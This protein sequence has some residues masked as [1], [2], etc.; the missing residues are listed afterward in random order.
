VWVTSSLT[1]I[2]TPTA[3]ALGNFDGIHRGHQVVL[4]PILEFAAQSADRPIPTVVTFHPHPRAFFSGKERPLLTPLAEKVE[5][6]SR[7]GIQQ[8]VRLSFNQSLANLS[9]SDF[10]RRILVQ[11]LDARYISVGSD[12]CFGYQRQGTTEDLC[13]IAQSFDIKVAVTPL[14]AQN[15]DRIS[16]SRIR[17]ALAI[18]D[19]ATVK[20]M[21]GRSYDLQGRVVE[22]QKLGRTLGFP[23]ANLALPP[24]KLLPAHG[25]YG[26]RVKLSESDRWGVMNLGMRP[27]VAGQSLTAE[28]HLLDWEG[29]LYGREL[30]VSLELFIRP[31]QKFSSLD[32]LKQQIQADCDR[33][34]QF[35][36]LECEI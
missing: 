26:V 20:Q 22:G 33:A 34:R 32:A 10:V 12:F 23:T 15:D 19:L 13:A 29:D 30:G 31:E 16:S 14:L 9:P 35:F 4:R 28:V 27:T 5:I 21:L 24:D 17:Q 8:L 6:L 3:I 11:S 2:K 1:D 7:L 18:A 25:V 36:R